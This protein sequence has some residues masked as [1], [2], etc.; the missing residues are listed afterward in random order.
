MHLRDLASVSAVS[1]V[2]GRKGREREGIQDSYN[3]NE[4]YCYLPY[5][6]PP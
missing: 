6:P 5:R 4:G 2:A 3:M 1:L